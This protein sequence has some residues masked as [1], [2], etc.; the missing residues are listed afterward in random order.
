MQINIPSNPEIIF[1]QYLTIMNPTFGKNSLKP[2]EIDILAKY[3]YIDYKYRHLPQEDRETIMFAQETKKRIRISLGQPNV[4]M[5]EA[6]FNNAMLKLRKKKFINKQS[7][8]IKV[9]IKDNKIELHFN[10]IIP[11]DK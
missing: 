7:L 10:L 9:P 11:N 6:S 2:M 5:S 4:P 1:K 8:L 3:L